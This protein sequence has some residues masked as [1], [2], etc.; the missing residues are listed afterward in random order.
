LPAVSVQ[1]QAQWVGSDTCAVC[2]ADIYKSFRQTGMGRS[3]S[4]PEVDRLAQTIKFEHTVYDSLS[5]FYYSVHAD[6]GKLVMREF[7]RDRGK[8]IH[9]QE[10]AAAYQV[11]S[12][13]HTLSFIEDRNGYLFEMPL[14][15]YSQKKLWDLSPG[16]RENNW[17]FDRPINGTCLNCHTG[18]SRLT[19]QTENHFEK[20]ALGIGCE[21]CH[22]P[23]SEHV[24][25]AL[26][27]PASQANFER[28]IVHPADLDRNLQMDIC[29]RCHLEG[30]R[31]W[32]EG[33]AAEQVEAGKPLASFQA[34]FIDAN[35]HASE[36][37]FGIAAQ[38]DRL[39][40]SACYQKSGIMTCTTCHDPHR[41][42]GAEN[43]NAHCTSCHG[44]SS[45]GIMPAAATA[46]KMPALRLPAASSCT[47]PQ[48]NIQDC[49]QCHMPTGET[50]D[51]PHVRF[52]D[53][54]IRRNFKE[55]SY[56]AHNSGAPAIPFLVPMIY[57]EIPAEKMLRHGLA[58][59]EYH[60]SG[61]GK[62]A[63]LDSTI[64]YL[65]AAAGHGASRHDGDDEY[66]K[67]SAYYLLGQVEL[68]E[69][70]LRRALAKNPAH[71]RAYYILG[72]LL[73][74]QNRP[75]EAAVI[76]ARG[77][78][79]QP[80]LLENILGRG[81]ALL[82]DMKLEEAVAT[83]GRM[84]TVDSLSYEQAYYYLGQVWRNAGNFALA[85]A[86][87]RRALALNPGLTLAQL[88]TGST[89]MLEENWQKAV[90]VF[91]QI[92]QKN[93]DYVPALFNKSICFANLN[94]KRKA[95][96][97]PQLRVE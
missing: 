41:H 38:A 83:F 37:D 24:R 36:T 55:E 22:G 31:V 35:A 45:A 27:S 44:G 96:V 60:Q 33:A 19:P 18:P 75:A 5:D 73:M 61:G 43:I 15:W 78:Q 93:P 70:A 49:V 6:A 13:N 4:R 20:V 12:G 17:R 97:M 79:A 95:Q 80:K 9:Q 92:L 29:Q 81:Q 89:F 72:K 39:R 48:K 11:G 50:S 82:T 54:Y 21:N 28:T 69:P 67:G 57:S 65:E 64:F 68:A 91:D 26:A 84:L 8:V 16:Y 66:A 7:R 2:H 88:N 3:F 25:V 56:V 76:F 32:N 40:K 94:Q 62:A 59:F 42:A 58:Y 63:Y 46:G 71:A 23:G 74:Q 53:H 90:A 77:E 51:I 34:V 86:S 47:A 14:T 85:R 1:V 52:T 30:L 87:Y 10:R